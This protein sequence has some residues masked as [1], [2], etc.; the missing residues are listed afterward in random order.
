MNHCRRNSKRRM[1][2]G[3]VVWEVFEYGALEKAQTRYQD[4]IKKVTF[5]LYTQLF[6]GF[7]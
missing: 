7:K 3:K 6:L 4:K 1:E 5:L 2:R